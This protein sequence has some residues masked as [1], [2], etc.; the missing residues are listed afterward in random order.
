MNL[1][2]GADPAGHVD[3]AADRLHQVL[4]DRQ[5]QPGAA[6]LAAARLVDAVEPLEDARQVVARDAD[7]GVGDLDAGF[8]VIA[9]AGHRDRAALRACT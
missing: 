9:E 2:A 6:E 7:A 8:V 3:L 4:D 1:R 5:T